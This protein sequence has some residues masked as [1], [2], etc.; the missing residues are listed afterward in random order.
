MDLLER[1]MNEYLISNPSINA[2]YLVPPKAAKMNI[3]CRR[4]I[5]KIKV[6]EYGTPSHMVNL[7]KL[8]KKVVLA[9]RMLT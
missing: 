5:Y 7:I 6:Y 2:I 4:I 9:V 3:V 8:K 1:G